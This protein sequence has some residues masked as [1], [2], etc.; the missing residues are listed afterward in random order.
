MIA[1]AMTQVTLF[2]P[3]ILVRAEYV[4]YA[5][6]NALA[7]INTK[8]IKKKNLKLEETQ[9]DLLLFFLHLVNV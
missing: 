8:K 6:L 5:L 2:P 3:R 9:P 4:R 7:T 1:I